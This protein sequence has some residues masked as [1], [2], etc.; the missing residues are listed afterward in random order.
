[1]KQWHALYILLCSYESVIWLDCFVGHNVSECFCPES[2]LL[3]LGI[4]YYYCVR[5]P[6]VHW[7]LAN[8]F[9]MVY[10][11]V[12]VSLRGLYHQSGTYSQ[13]K[14]APGP[15]YH[16]NPNHP[17]PTRLPFSAIYGVAS[18]QLTH[19]ILNDWNYMFVTHLIII[20]KSEVSTFL[21]LSYFLWLWVRGGC[22]NI[23]VVSY[24]YIP[25]T[26]RYRAIDCHAHIQFELQVAPSIFHALHI[27]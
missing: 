3:L 17:P 19:S 23:F 4:Q 11:S 12:V 9:W 8:L 26:L 6:T 5:Y 22:T 1:M 24:I 27:S 16:T 25:E 10:F 18:V 21:L 13:K 20:I 14:P 15:M 2:G 7:H